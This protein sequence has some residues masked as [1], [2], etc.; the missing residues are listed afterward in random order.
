MSYYKTH[1]AI[2]V[3]ISTGATVGTM[4]L[5]LAGWQYSELTPALAVGGAFLAGQVVRDFE[6]L[7]GKFD[8]VALVFYGGIACVIGALAWLIGA[9]PILTG[10]LFYAGRETRDFE[11]LGWFDR[12]GFLWPVVPLCG[13]EI[14]WRVF[15]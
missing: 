1:L 7:P 4:Q 13:A 5:A 8:A 6:K 15:M 2:A 3:A 12:L 14:L 9:T 10:A 11:K